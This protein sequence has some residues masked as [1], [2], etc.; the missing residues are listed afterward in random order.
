MAKKPM[1]AANA[2][3]LNR[4]AL[5]NAKSNTANRLMDKAFENGKPRAG[6]SVASRVVNKAA[7]WNLYEQATDNLK[8]ESMAKKAGARMGRAQSAAAAKKKPK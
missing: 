3:G 2:R 1:K 8:K 6:T 5:F 4:E 7:A